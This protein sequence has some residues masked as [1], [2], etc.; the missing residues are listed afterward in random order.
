[1]RSILPLTEINGVGGVMVESAVYNPNRREEWI[2]P[3]NE[4]C[5]EA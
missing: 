3:G 2:F 1:M 4:A 5:V